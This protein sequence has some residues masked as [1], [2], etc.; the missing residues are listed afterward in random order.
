MVGRG[1]PA[2]RT[3]PLA[4]VEAGGAAGGVPCGGMFGYRD[5]GAPFRLCKNEF[6]DLPARY[7]AGWY[8]G[9]ATD[10]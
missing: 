9:I 3:A 4:R 5:G 2:H 1:R 8:L 10:G 6:L 7:D